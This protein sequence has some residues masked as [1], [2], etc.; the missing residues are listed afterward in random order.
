MLR[1]GVVGLL[2]VLTSSTFLFTNDV[3][4]APKTGLFA[5]THDQKLS[6][7]ALDR[8]SPLYPY[9]RGLGAEETE[10]RGGQPPVR[11]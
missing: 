4:S 8:G 7:S 3:Y 9:F 6:T 1:I 2:S 5:L 11:A 10:R